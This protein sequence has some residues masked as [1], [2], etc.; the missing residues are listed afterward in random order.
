MQKLIW[1]CAL[2]SIMSAIKAQKKPVRKNLKNLF[3]DSIQLIDK[4]EADLQEL[5]VVQLGETE[6]SEQSLGFVPSLLGSGRD[7][8]NSMSAFHFN[9]LRFRPRG[10][11]GI[12]NEVNINGISMN[13]TMDGITQFNSWNGLNTQMNNAQISN[14]GIINGNGFGMLGQSNYVDM[15]AS[16]QRVQTQFGY[17]FSNRNVTHRF[18]F[19]TAS[20]KNGKGWSKAFAF[21]L[22]YG[23]EGYFPGTYAKGGSY[24]FGLDKRL[25]NADLLSFITF[26]SVNNNG[27][28]SAIT[29]ESLDLN[30]GEKYNP[31]WGYQNGIK[32]NA[33]RSFSFLPV[34]ILSFEHKYTNQSFLKISVG[35]ITGMKGT[36]ALDRYNAADPRPDYYRYL[37]GYQ[38]DSSL[39][40]RLY[41]EMIADKELRQ[42]NWSSLYDI[43]RNSN[44]IVRDVEGISGNEIRGKRAHYIISEKDQFIHHFAINAIFHSNVK[45]LFAFSGGFGFQVNTSRFQMRV[46][47]LLGADFFVDI[48][49]FASGDVQ[50][51]TSVMQNDL[52]HPNRIVHEGE[53]YGYD[54]SVI[55]Q[56][57][58][59]W[60][61]IAFSKRRFD[62][63]LAGSF[64]YQYFLREGHMRN[65]TFP[66]ASFGRSEAVE[67]AGLSIKANITYKANGK[68]YFYLQGILENRP[69]LFDDV[70]VSPRTRNETQENIANERI[71]SV[72]AGFIYHPSSLSFKVSAYYTR[73]NHR[74]NVMNFYHDGYGTFVNYALTGI[75]RLHFGI[76]SGMEWKLSNR[77]S[78]NTAVSIGRYYENSRPFYKITSDNDAA[79]L[80]KGLVYIKDFRVGGTPQEALGIGIKYQSKS[81]FYGEITGSVFAADWLDINPIRRT[82][83]AMENVTAGSEKWEQ[84]ISQTQLPIQSSVDISAGYSIRSRLLGSKHK[85]T[86]LFFLGI[87]NLLNKKDLISGGFEQLRYDNKEND[88]MKF[89]PKFYY[90]MGLNFSFH[91]TLRLN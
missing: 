46:N 68:K 26:G 25:N 73:I 56:K 12:Y 29:K 10:Y 63:S 41:D 76:E 36:T 22:R 35:F 45:D 4:G 49:Q 80:E 62:Y 60:F 38:K 69:P 8:F 72:E 88:P 15:R 27:R 43:N 91:I 14:A 89:P 55:N 7:L 87:N 39:R 83:A 85:Q 28:Q 78:I 33:N 54:Y 42:I 77:F 79:E 57:V 21:N 61:E 18:D 65:G 31:S 90:A 40:A 30:S 74:M 1:L 48:N 59:S 32:R 37:P 84:L 6:R 81:S 64:N 34:S 82:Y 19:A 58:N 2:L 75:D 17:T 53:K 67:S 23:D 52:D 13:F 44:E 9:V 20:N 71:C 3:A 24:Y 16:G 5:P 51:S 70:F 50:N 66:Y 11:D 86:I 47:D